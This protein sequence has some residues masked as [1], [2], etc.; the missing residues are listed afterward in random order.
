[1]KKNNKITIFINGWNEEI[2][3]EDVQ[4]IT[5]GKS[6]FSINNSDIDIKNYLIY[7]N[8]AESFQI[9]NNIFIIIVLTFIFF[10]FIFFLKSIFRRYDTNIL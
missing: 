3:S 10:F 4:L 9:R 2:N 7:I 1:M 8:D 6:R 5:S